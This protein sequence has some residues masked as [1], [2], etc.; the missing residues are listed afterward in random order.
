MHADAVTAS[1]GAVHEGAAEHSLH[2]GSEK[3]AVDKGS[4]GANPT[5]GKSF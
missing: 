5:I 3:G 2:T 1:E 4:Y